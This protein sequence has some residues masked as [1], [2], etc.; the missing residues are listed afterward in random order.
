[1]L[2]L[3]FSHGVSATPK[4][5]LESYQKRIVAA[6]YTTNH[7]LAELEARETL[8]HG[9]YRVVVKRSGAFLGYFTENGEITGDV[10]GW[11][12]VHG[13]SISQDDLAFLRLA[14]VQ[15]IR[16]DRLVKVQY[17]N[18]GGRKMFLASALD[19]GYC[20]AMEKNLALHSKNF[21]T[22]FYILP[23]ALDSRPNRSA[24]SE[25]LWKAA[26]D[27]YCSENPAESWK[28]FW[29]NRT[30]T[31]IRRQDC[32]VNSHMLVEEERFLKELL[33]SVGIKVNG[34]PRIVREDSIPFTPPATSDLSTLKKLYGEEGLKDI[35]AIMLQ[36]VRTRFFEPY[37]GRY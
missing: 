11:E 33:A 7:S 20:G 14:L 4:S 15:N 1:M 13:K 16:Y 6:G 30:V 8:V 24:K 5:M 27:I 37:D 10:N 9:I 12:D 28:K 26:A 25:A 18:G 3:F 35:D 23:S 36:R 17:G 31:G 22:T 19:C 29:V 32:N 34:T 2:A 21:N